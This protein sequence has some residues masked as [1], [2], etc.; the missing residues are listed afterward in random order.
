MSHDVT[1]HLKVPLG[2][3]N[4]INALVIL[5]ESLWASSDV[6]CIFFLCPSTQAHQFVTRRLEQYLVR[7]HLLHPSESCSVIL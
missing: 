4:Y 6:D 3:F 1:Y 7:I 2:I 5:F